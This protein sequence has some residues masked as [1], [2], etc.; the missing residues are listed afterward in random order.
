M[1][2]LSRELGWAAIVCLATGVA[3]SCYAAGLESI[4]GTVSD[5]S[6]AL[7][8]GAKVELLAKGNYV[9]NTVTNA[10]GRYAVAAAAPGSY[11]LRISA[12]AFRTTVSTVD[13]PSG[14]AVQENVTL[15]LDTLAQKVTV[16]A[17]G[18][19]VRQ[20][21]I[22]SA[23]TV[24]TREQF[25]GAQ[26]IQQAL[27]QIPGLQV[28]Q[29]GQTGGVTTLF[30]RGGNSDSNK[31]LI[32]GIGVNDIGGGVDFANIASAGIEKIEVLRGPNSATYGSDAL[33]GV[34]SLSTPRGTTPLPKIGYLGEGG[35]FATYHQEGT[36]SGAYRRFDYLA[37]YSRF[38]IAN[39]VPRDQFHNGTVT[40]NFGWT[41]TAASSLRATLH[42][43]Q[44]ASGQPSALELYG[45]ADAAK[46]NS[47]DGYIGVTFENQTRECW[48]NL[49][50]YG[51]VRLRSQYTHFAPT[52]MP[53]SDGNGGITG[54]LGAPVTLSGANGYRVSG[55]AQF[56]YPG[57]YPSRYPTSTD[58]DFVYAQSDYRFN[59]HTVGLAAFKYED[60]R[61][62][63]GGPAQS[64]ERGNYSYTV[65]VEG[66]LG[67]R[68]HYL[69]G[70]GLEKNALF[71][72]AATP[73]VSLAYDLVR[74][75][76]A[77]TKLRASFGKGIKEPS[78]SDQQSSLYALLSGLSDGAQLLTQYRV[79]QIGAQ[80]SRS[81]DGGV[82]QE[83]LN[84]R[85]SVTLFHSEFT[86]GIEYI[87]QQG[88]LSL[89]VPAPVVD[90]AQ[91]GA[92]LNTQAY[93]A[94][95][96]EVE[97]EYRIRD[98][99]FARG[100]YTYLDAVVQR[101][102]SSDALGPAFNPAIPGVPIGIYTPLIGARPFRRAPHSGY[103][104]LSYDH[105]RFGALLTGTLVGS[106]DDSDFLQYDANNTQSLLLPNRNLD[107]AYQRLDLAASYRVNDTVSLV[108]SFGNLLSQH[109]SE[110]FGYPS[111]PFTFR[112]GVRLTIGGESWKLR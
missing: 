78:L 47:E 33:A 34:V 27:R 11:Q 46:Q 7:V 75:A 52:G 15:P 94:Q 112:S 66:D 108:S 107:G 6:G 5:P 22:G 109:Y 72:F 8:G 41:P 87:P 91:F 39:S 110:A 67:G 3:A 61:G 14:G 17:T 4:S 53:E 51:G 28:T 97:G 103:F 76:G 45:I 29:T 68:L 82:D 70:S 12:P 106:R 85:A 58:R 73:R 96:V 2:H 13:V 100:G 65:Q 59:P 37:D 89:G 54:Y 99:V 83:F 31:V 20:S 1:L 16:T 104:G 43:D 40:G 74:S 101:S 105:S 21:Q 48:H 24:L 19:P 92:T 32:D 81:F 63:A 60:E 86:G 57:V 84:G 18:T 55:Q 71:G 88:L 23:V 80:R 93:R 64:I 38:D 35:N 30:V 56:Q 79:S 111:L 44:V 95:G 36:L 69:V 25:K 77:S 98:H 10:E 102:F 49:L 26:E 42:H 9:T 90:A 62:Y 50:R